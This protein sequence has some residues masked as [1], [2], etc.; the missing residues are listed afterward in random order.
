MAEG[1][2]RMPHAASAILIAAP[3]ALVGFAG[4][5]IAL[6]T[7]TPQADADL[8]LIVASDP[9][10]VARQAGGRP[11]GPWQAPIGALV[12]AGS[13]DAAG[14]AARLSAAGAWIVLDG[15]AVAAICGVKA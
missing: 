6:G 11:I 5:L 3:M 10:S 2:P 15:A 7:A 1:L 9:A 13:E 14:F 12:A 4:P 8:L